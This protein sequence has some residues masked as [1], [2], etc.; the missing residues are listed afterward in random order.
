MNFDFLETAKT[1]WQT[2]WY[3]LRRSPYQ[4]VAIMVV[5]TLCLFVTTLF[6]LIAGGAEKTLKTLESQPEVIAFFVQPPT[7]EELEQLKAQLIGTGVIKEIKYVSQEEALEKYRADNKDNPLLLE[8]VTADILPASVEVSTKNP[9]SL[10]QIAEILNTHENVDEVIYQKDVIEKLVKWTKFLRMLGIVLISVLGVMSFLTI[11]IIIGL[12]IALRR[13]EVE[14]LRLIGASP[15]FIRWPFLLEGAIYGL[16]G[17]FVGWGLSYLTLLYSTPYVIDLIWSLQLLPVSRKW[18]IA[19]L[20]WELL[21][22]SLWG[23]LAAFWAVNR[24]LARGR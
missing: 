3:H 15:G 17:A 9:E 14:I 4:S 19:L 8:M 11:F 21:A 13:N 18:M 5:L 23:A 20:G 24:Y 1:H 22:G 7:N 10:S 12:K 2:A 16:I 6:I